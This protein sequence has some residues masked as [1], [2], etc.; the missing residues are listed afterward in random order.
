MQYSKI[1]NGLAHQ[2][3][4]VHI[5]SYVRSVLSVQT[6]GR[7]SA[8]EALTGGEGRACGVRARAGTPSGAQ[9]HSSGLRSGR[10]PIVLAPLCSDY[11]YW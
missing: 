5:Y 4:Y 9:V 7:S 1:Y 10:T 6:P 11:L 8:N 2:K 3:Y